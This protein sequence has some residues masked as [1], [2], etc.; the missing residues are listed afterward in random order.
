VEDIDDLRSLGEML[1]RSREGQALSIEEVEGHTRIRRKY[2]EAFENGNFSVLP[3]PAHAKGFLR[4]YALF[5][6]LDANAI[7]Q[8]FSELAGISTG[9]LTRPT[10]P[11]F[12]PPPP[13]S[14]R[15]SDTGAF[16]RPEFRPEAQPNQPSQQRQGS[17][18]ISPERQVGPATPLPSQSIKR[19]S[20]PLPGNLFKRHTQQPP[21]QEPQPHEQP[22]V[23]QQPG[24]LPPSEGTL[25]SRIVHSPFFTIGVLG[26]GFVL[27]VIFIVLQ[28]RSGQDGE[29]VVTSNGQERITQRG[30]DDLPQFEPQTAAT[31]EAPDNADL[32]P[33]ET[34]DRVIISIDV[35][36]RAWTRITVDGELVYE[37][38][39]APGT[40]LQYEGREEIQVYTGNGAGLVVNYNGQNQGALG[41]RGEVVDRRYAVGGQVGGPTPTPT[42]TPTNT[43][44]P[45]PTPPGGG[46][47][48][49]RNGGIIPG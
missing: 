24:Q 41:S 42:V 27:V 34:L 7:V 26:A 1:R 19:S 40:T 29:A 11:Q 44:V 13:N 9:T 30:E 36:Q 2:I 8:R 10:A 45:S 22:E 3:S 16:A 14:Y 32:V 17:T 31:P 39:A 43:Q 37:D 12:R 48:T 33:P 6:Q 5:L 15:R 46:G 35:E 18:Y 49:E 38:L 47:S 4:N 21:A 20:I 25:P 28:V 23:Q